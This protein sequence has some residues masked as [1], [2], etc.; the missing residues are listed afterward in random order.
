VKESPASKHGLAAEL[1]SEW[2]AAER[3]TAAAKLAESV[4]K[5]AVEAAAVAE[6]AAV[7]AEDAATAAMEAAGR[8]KEAAVK[9]RDVAR[10]ASEGALMTEARAEGDGD[11]HQ[12]SRRG[13]CSGIG[14]RRTAMD[15]VRGGSR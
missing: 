2:R 9:A 4:A 3:D 1:L 15:R 8:A 14:P 12:R 6:A 10:W 7:D 11:D 5:L 13:S